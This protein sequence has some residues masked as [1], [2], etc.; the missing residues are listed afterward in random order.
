MLTVAIKRKPLTAPS[1]AL[2]NVERQS[3]ESMLRYVVLL[4]GEVCWG[5][6]SRLTLLESLGFTIVFMLTFVR[7]ELH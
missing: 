7:Y 4:V 2:P 1:F 6:G 3:K 5:V